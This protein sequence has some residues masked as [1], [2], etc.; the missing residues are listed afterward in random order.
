[1]KVSKSQHRNKRRA[2]VRA[3]ISGTSLVPRIS[4]FRSN[5]HLFVQIIDDESRK[6]VVSSIIKS[7]KKSSLKGTKTESA[8]VIGETL[9]KKAQESGITKVVFDRGG[10]KYHGRVKA[11]AEGLRKGGLKF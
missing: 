3:K 2:R 5:R 10:Y 11:L 4:V 9:A 8:S 1:M 7:K 6:T